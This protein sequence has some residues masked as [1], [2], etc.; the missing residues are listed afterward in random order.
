M[1]NE[2]TT[3]VPDDP[4]A[5][6]DLLAEDSEVEIKEPEDEKEEKE[7]LNLDEKED[8]EDKEEPETEIDIS[9]PPRKAQIKAKYPKI[10]EEFPYLEKIIYRDR[11]IAETF[12]SFDNLKEAAEKASRL[13]ELEGQVLSGSSVEFFSQ[14]V[15]I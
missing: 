9:T 12:G 8:K 7:I 10:F 5:I 2:E 13:D 1:P 15:N 4:G 11:E 6:A 3:I 14:I